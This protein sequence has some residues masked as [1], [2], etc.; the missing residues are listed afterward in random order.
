MGSYDGLLHRASY[1]FGLR[2]TQLIADS[3]DRSVA[4]DEPSLSDLL[5]HLLVR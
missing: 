2:S 4:A 3:M 5:R 1:L